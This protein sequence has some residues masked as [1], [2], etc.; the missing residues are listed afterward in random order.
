M[1]AADELLDRLAKIGAIVRPAGDS[2]VVRA[3]QRPVPIELV[4]RLRET[5]VE[6][7]AALSPTMDGSESAAQEK[8]TDRPDDARTW[9]DLYAMRTGHWFHGERRWHEA[10]ALA[11][12]DLENR[13]N[14]AHGERVLPQICAGCRR[15]IGTAETPALVDGN[16]VH[17]HDGCDCLIRHGERWRAAAT[18]ALIAMG[19]VPPA[20]G[21]GYDQPA[22]GGHTS[23]ADEA[24][25]GDQ[26]ERDHQHASR[27]QG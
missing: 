10:E 24:R 16:R 15:P 3:G 4:R 5:K 1:S 25:A 27:F 13:W 18:R 17:L 19:L 23:T 14:L 6:I 9:R 11:W 26:G 21:I 8:A 7:L 12:S 2:L 20:M 22:T